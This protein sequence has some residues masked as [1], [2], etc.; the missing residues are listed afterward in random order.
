MSRTS[1]EVPDA[2]SRWLDANFCATVAHGPHIPA[3]LGP[4]FDRGAG[5]GDVDRDACCRF[6]GGE[7]FIV[8][9]CFKGEAGRR[10]GLFAVSDMAE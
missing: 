3:L 9:F 2:S 4:S 1:T 10:Y 8:C 7:I 5:T 6:F